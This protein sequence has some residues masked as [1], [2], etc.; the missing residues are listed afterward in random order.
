[1]ADGAGGDCDRGASSFSCTFSTT[2]AVTFLLLTLRFVNFR[3]CS[4]KRSLFDVRVIA[5]E[6]RNVIG[7][8]PY[9]GAF[10]RTIA[11]LPFLFVF[12]FLRTKPG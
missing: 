1:M 6:F 5:F 4:I 12:D 11:L 7:A 10:P 3:D 9:F 8:G 2:L